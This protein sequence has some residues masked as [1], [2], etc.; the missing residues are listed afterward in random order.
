MPQSEGF[1][2]I[3][4]RIFDRETISR[5][6]RGARIRKSYREYTREIYLQTGIAVAG[7]IAA[8]VVFHLFSIRFTALKPYPFWVQDALVLIVPGMMV[9]LALYFQP[10]LA[11]KG[12]R[13]RI[14]M[15]LPYAITYMQALSTTLTLYNAIR[16]V[17][18][19][20]D[21]YGEVSR[22]FG[23]IVRDVEVFGDD[24]ITAMRN[25]G[26]TTPSE[27]LKKLLD[28]LI[29][30]FESGGDLPSFLSS[31]SSHYREIAEKELE[32]SLK[33]MEIMAEVYVTAFVAAPIAVIIMVVAENMSGQ[34]TLSALMPYFFIFL[35]IGAAAMVWIL[36]LVVPG[37]NV[38]ITRRES[39]DT[40]FGG[41][42]PMIEGKDRPDPMFSRR[43]E[44]RKKLLRVLSMIKSPLRSYMS[45]YRFGII[46]GTIFGSV[47]VLMAMMGMFQGLFPQYPA[48][49]MIC[50]MTIAMLAP[51]A[52][53]YEARRFYVHQVET[54]VPDFL[55]ELLDLKDIGMTLQGAVTL[56]S[57]SKIGLLSSEL[58]LVSR[59]VKFG[60]SI[61]SALVRLEERIGVLVIKRVISLI[62]RASEVTDYIR[63]ILIIAIDDM[64][65]FLKMKRER[66]TVSFAYIMIIYLSFG[67][68]LYTA[69]QLN[70]SFITSFEKLNTNIDISGNVLDMFRMSI[71]LGI[72]SG[73]M[74]GQL[75][76]G[77]ILAGFKHVIL[78]LVAAVGLFVYVL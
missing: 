62:I 11:A 12:R 29:L 68:F 42:I 51:L 7:A 39:R 36:S 47:I 8:L 16:G 75:S 56:I 49:I 20:G 45:D 22:E 10:M 53:A 61:T 69:Y 2:R 74:A 34:S 46:A 44:A 64:E 28:D 57:E 41:G 43:I 40:E 5:N 17:Y 21:L 70:V 31:R 58:K 66:Y 59:D 50:L 23:M 63:D 13:A 6:L 18:E 25:L 52:L 19:Q 3:T 72:F 38:V 37:E 71:I 15:D 35:P 1:S 30:M 48:E 77:S 24:L 27:N 54:Q 14:E 26:R 32:M 9:F 65:H 67:I 78:F 33:T 55:R 76:S 73:V 4:D 60:T